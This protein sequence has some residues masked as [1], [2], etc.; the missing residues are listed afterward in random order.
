MKKGSLFNF[1]LGVLAVLIM[2]GCAGKKKISGA[3][4]PETAQEWVHFLFDTAGVHS[5]LFMIEATKDL[6]RQKPIIDYNSHSL[7][8]PASNTKILTLFASLKFLPEH[9]HGFYWRTEN[10]TTFIRGAA[11]PT[12]L[13]PRF[14]SGPAIEFLESQ[15]NLVFVSDWS[16][17][18]RFGPG[19]G[20][21]DYPYYYQPEKSPFP[22]YGNVMR[23][24][25]RN[26]TWKMSP[27]G[28]IVNE[29]Q[30]S[31][32]SAVRRNEDS[33]IFQVKTDR[34]QDENFTLRLP[35]IWTPDEFTRLLGD[36]LGIDVAWRNITSADKEEQWEIFPGAERD[37]LLRTLMY[38]SD[39]LIAEQLAWNISS[40]LWDTL[41]TRRTIDSMMNSE[42]EE[43]KGKIRWADGSGLSVYNAFSP[44]F[45][46][47]LLQ[48]LHRSMPE[49]KLFSFFPAGG[50]RGTIA[51]WYGGEEGPFVFAKT[52]TLSGTHT[53]SGYLKADSGKTYIFSFMHNN[54]I[55]S[56]NQ[57]KEKME[58]LLN[59]LKKNY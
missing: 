13:D 21:D 42:F 51:S 11:D 40:T 24:Q 12:F 16:K 45:L 28:F 57:Y 37:S 52:G 56:S 19:W 2:T 41:D 33:N 20:W 15:K 38:P 29:V 27:G 23:A 36:T 35:F 49:E 22:I 10:D 43:W 47:E 46:A 53:L 26:G 8:T 48:K 58:V 17:A 55:G 30:N 50:V 6:D 9:I 31:P 7:F 4:E 5:G 25:C 34:C 14:D 44:Q 32:G 18:F 3:A 1:V 59:W 54:F 39:N